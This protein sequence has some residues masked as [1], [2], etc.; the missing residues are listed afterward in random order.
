ML[1]TPAQLATLKADILADG[2]LNAFPNTSDGNF[3]IARQYGFIVSPDFF[4]YRTAIPIS[5]IF[6]QITWANF[7]P[8][9]PPTDPVP[10]SDT[11]ITLQRWQNR[12][13]HAQGK[14]FNVQILLST[15]G[16]NGVINGAKSKVRAGLQDALTNV[17]TGAAGALLSAGWVGVRDN[18]LARKA[19]RVEKLFA[20]ISGG[21]GSSASLAATLV[22]E[23]AIDADTVGLARSS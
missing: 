16:L 8:V 1:L 4:V 15:G 10:A 12:A 3:E 20:N 9:D 17:P 5:E 6:D 14:Q 13:L 22:I 7:T 23:G 19:I 2:T 21:N 18:A 11:A